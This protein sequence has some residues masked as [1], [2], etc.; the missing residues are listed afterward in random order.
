MTWLLLSV[1]IVCEVIGTTFLKLSEGFSRLLPT[2]VMVVCY[3][4]AFWCLS[5]T[6][7][8]IPTGIIYAIWSGVGIVLIGVVGWIFLGQKLDLP[9]MLGMGLIIAGVIVINLFSRAVA[10]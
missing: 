5:V 7:R 10:H 6:M 8:T 2:L 9:A 4:I 3:G 1:A